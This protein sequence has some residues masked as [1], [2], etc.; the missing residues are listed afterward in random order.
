L[1]G[2]EQQQLQ[3]NQPLQQAAAVTDLS[4]LVV[5]PA[6]AAERGRSASE[7]RAMNRSGRTI[8]LLAVLFAGIVIGSGGALLYL[9]D[10]AAVK[11][12]P[13][14]ASDVVHNFEPKAFLDAVAGPV[15]RK[16]TPIRFTSADAG[17]GSRHEGEV[18]A[19]W[20]CDPAQRPVGAR[21]PIFERLVQ[22]VERS[23]T[24]S[25]GKITSR[26]DDK[27]PYKNDVSAFE[28]GY[29][30]DKDGRTRY[31]FVRVWC[32]AGHPA[33]DESLGVIFTLVMQIKESPSPDGG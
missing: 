8:T 26:V 20:H 14:T 9:R 21:P 27:F 16:D 19:F 28:R 10:R 7:E 15:K 1:E 12:E 13:T 5:Q 4:L 2:S 11:P 29:R 17:A 18:I 6:A 30:A 24:S 23:I 33:Q 22:A 32:V 31:G 25:G 3:P